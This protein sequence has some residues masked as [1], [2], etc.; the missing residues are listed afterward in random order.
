MAHACELETSIC[1]AI[2]PDAVEME[3]AL[4]ERGFPAGEYS[5]MEWSDGPMRVMPWWSAF[6]VT[7][8]QGDA[9]KGTAEKGEAF[10]GCG[11]R[12]VPRLRPRPARQAPARAARAAGDAVTPPPIPL[13]RAA[14]S[15]REVGRQIGAAT[16][17]EMAR[18]V[19]EASPF[20]P[21]LIARYRAVTVE[22][23]PWVV[24]E[25]DGAA[26][27]AGLDPLAVFAAS[28]E[29]LVPDEAP[30]GCTDLVVTGAHTAD[31]HCSSRTR[32]TCTR[33]RRPGSSRSSGASRAARR[34]H[35]RRRPVGQRRL[36]RRRPVRDR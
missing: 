2:D 4:D 5:Y 30:T 7:G 14:G 32:T 29:E 31:G 27:G 16:A 21:D 36:E 6:S 17:G 18:M 22:H 33:R 34:L 23:L 26:E 13:I 11:G 24:E 20:D 15:H 10:L 9:S 35:P 1:L 3:K 25:L 28:I 8:I 12:G 19:E